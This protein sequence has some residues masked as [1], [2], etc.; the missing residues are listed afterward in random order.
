MRVLQI[1]SVVNTGSTGR[2]AEDIGRVL[3]EAGHE[4]FIAAANINRGS[5]SALIKTGNKFDWI[6]HVLLSRFFDMH[7]FGSKQATKKLV[8]EIELINPDIIHLHNIHG[9]YLNIGV[10]FQYLKK[11]NTPVVWTFHDCW[12]FTG[13]CSYFDYVQCDKWQ[14]GC[15]SCPNLKGYPTAW[16][17]DRSKSNF[18]IKKELFSKVDKLRI[19]T[20]SDWLHKIVGKS[21]LSDYLCQVIHNGIDLALFCPGQ[22]DVPDDILH[23]IAGKKVIL[24]VAS[25]WDR[26]KGLSDFIRLSQLLDNS[27]QI[28]L[29]GLSVKQ[30][31]E[32]PSCIVALERTERISQLASLY[33]C[34]DVFVNPTYVDNFPTTNIEALA[35]GTPVVTYNTG[36]SPEAI[37]TD[38]GF[39]VSKGDMNALRLAI[40]KTIEN[41]KSYYATSCRSRAEQLF[42]KSSRYA[43][44]L[45]LYFD[46]LSDE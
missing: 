41:G 1:N 18:K 9:Y 17:C 14:T 20:P 25:T 29:V 27:F 24:G 13:H 11:R 37:D 6:L 8:Q 23:R 46:L 34:A 35:C 10:L 21:F 15:K 19:I 32:M 40:L 26:R 30:L 42:N 2:I 3:I 33:S 4:S 43:D 5:Y 16:F 44:Y 12:P 22:T 38:T 39:V 28:I 45:S 31:K 7:G 36:G